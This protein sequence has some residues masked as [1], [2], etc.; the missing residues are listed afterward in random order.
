MG[1]EYVQK[2]GMESSEKDVIMEAGIHLYR[3]LNG[4]HPINLSLPLYLPT[5]A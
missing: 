3:R 4:M 1:H 5:P 2:S